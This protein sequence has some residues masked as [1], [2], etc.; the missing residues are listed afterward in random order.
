[1][2]IS[3]KG[4]ITSKHEATMTEA[5]LPQSRENNLHMADYENENIIS[6]KAHPVVR[7]HRGN[8]NMQS[9]RAQTANTYIAIEMRLK[10]RGKA[11]YLELL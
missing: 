9:K 3:R 10:R 2:K 8:H 11:D 7:N 6:S 4:T 5:S 1:M